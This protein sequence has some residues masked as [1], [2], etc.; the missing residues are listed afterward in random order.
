M[1]RKLRIVFMIICFSIVLTSCEGDI[2]GTQEVQT[3]IPPKEILQ[4]TPLPTEN[5]INSRTRSTDGMEMVSV[6]T[7]NFLMGSTEVEIE[8]AIALC[9]Q[10]YSPCNP[11][12]Y[13]RESP[14]HSV[15]LSRYWIDQTE[16]TNSQYRLCVEAGF[17]PE[18]TQCK[19]GDPTYADSQKTDHPVVCVN[20]E[21]AQTYC[22]WAGA[23]L[24]TEAEWEYAARGGA[25][26]IFP[27]GADFDGTRL[28]YC[29]DSCSQPHSDN[30]FD[31]GHPQTAPAGSFL[32]GT[33]WSGVLSLG[34][35]VSEW[36]SDWFGLYSSESQ[37][38]PMGPISGS[39]KM[40]KGCNWFSNP[41]YCRGAAR[42]AVDAE[43]R[44][45]YLGFRCAVPE[46]TLN[47]KG[48]DVVP[49][50]IVVPSGD[51]PTIDGTIDSGEWDDAVIGTLS[52]G[53][54]LLLMHAGGYLYLGIR[55][56][57]PEMIV[58]N[59][60]IKQ[61]DE[62]KILHSSAALGTALYH[63]SKDH[64]Q[65][66]QEFIWRCRETNESESAKT[67]RDVFFGEEGWVS[68]NSRI[69]TPNELEYQ[70]ELTDG[71]LQLAV[72]IIRSSEPNIKPSWPAYLD[73]DVIIPTP[74]GLPST[75]NFSLDQWGWLTF[76]SSVYSD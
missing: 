36:V 37:T 47:N 18:P 31:D 5:P 43:T 63:K 40:I 58:G 13:E 30:R 41:A 39:E 62:I 10:H 25:G 68:V 50:S 8:D 44:F 45:N 59:V 35:N 26:S 38:D 28:N 14:L 17:C 22:H 61:G 24:P 56:S 64:W 55:G 46:E 16:V 76:T 60:F 15:T 12:Y 48:V 74:G 20:W 54:E 6:P 19:K 32:Q 66:T 71:T 9:Q 23:R 34:G 2:S 51:H 73:D 53:S 33:S 69:G 11:W 27:W 1:D 4:P 49:N 65:Q 29:D 3:D 72:N 57:T 7:G 75:L 52:D 21:E 67:A 70:I 42:P